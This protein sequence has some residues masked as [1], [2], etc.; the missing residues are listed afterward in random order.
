MKKFFKSVALLLCIAMLFSS[1]ASKNPADNDEEKTTQPQNVDVENESGP[2]GDGVISLPYNPT[3]GLN[4]YFARSNENIY[5]CQLLFNSL[6]SVDKNYNAIPEIAESVVVNGKKAAVQL[7]SDAS[8]R[9]SQNINAYDVVYSFNLAKASYAWSGYLKGISKAEVRSKFSVE[10]TLDYSDIYVGAKLCFPIVKEGTADIET[11]VPTG[12]GQYYYL[13]GKLMNSADSSKSI[14]L[15]GIDT[16][17]SAENAFK[18]GSTDVYFNDLSDCEYIGI[19]GKTEEVLLNNLVYLGLNNSNG[20]LNKYVRSA[21]AA[22]INS[23]DVVLSAYQGHGKAVKNPVN[24]QAGYYDSIYVISTEGDSA[25]AD[26]ILDRAGFIRY[27]GRAK[28]NGAY[29]LSFSLI[30]NKDNK[31]RL[32]AAYS[33]ADSLNEAG[34]FITVKPLSFADYKERISS[35]SYDM[36]I[37]EVKLDGS[38]DVSGFFTE[39]EALNSGIDKSSRVRKEYFRYRAGKISAEEY[40]NIFAEEYPFVPIMFRNGFVVTSAD[41]AEEMSETPFNLYKNL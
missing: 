24:P 18:I 25:L 16:N 23:E 34:F 12:S 13:E 33:I 11:A 39:G 37:G 28:T 17:K 15:Y 14:R 29:T 21:I 6:F 26:K 22:K 8:C 1:C 27:S 10:F 32:A 41:V 31:Y 36:Y 3:D 20:A 7:R 4:P 38:M 2:K 19:S 9:G 35:G 40:Y 30:V 5:I